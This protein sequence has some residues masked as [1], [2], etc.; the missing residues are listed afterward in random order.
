MSIPVEYKTNFGMGPYNH[1]QN[2]VWI[3][4]LIPMRISKDW[5]LITRILQPIQ[6]QPYLSQKAGG[7]FGLGDMNPT[8]FLSPARRGILAWGAGPTFIVPT[9]TNRIL[10]QGK[11]SLGPELALFVQPGH[12]TYGT[13]ISNIWSVAGSGGR[14]K[15]NQMQL[16]YFISY[17]LKKGWDIETSPIITANWKASRGNIWTVPVGGGLGKIVHFGSRPTKVSVQFY[18]TAVRPSGAPSWSMRLQTEFLFPK[19][20]TQREN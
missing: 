18:P 11:F 16:Q 6:W 15:V 20:S 9:A 8:F 4:P 10:G 14:P 7:E 13:L 1:N 3:K 5:R 12:W 19:R 17:A 2:S